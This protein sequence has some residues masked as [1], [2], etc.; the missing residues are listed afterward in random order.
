MDNKN[1]GKQEHDE[2]KVDKPQPANHLPRNKH[3]PSLTVSWLSNTPP[4]RTPKEPKTKV[5]DNKGITDTSDDE[6][7]ISGSGSGSD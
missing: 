4:D 6:D 7:F 3:G 5:G 2:P 1:I